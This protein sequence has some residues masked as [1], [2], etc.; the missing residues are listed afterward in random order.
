MEIFIIHNLK[1]GNRNEKK[2][3]RLIVYAI[4]AQ[5][6]FGTFQHF[7]V[8]IGKSQSQY[9]YRVGQQCKSLKFWISL[10]VTGM[11]KSHQSNDLLMYLAHNNL[12]ALLVTHKI[13]LARDTIHPGKKLLKQNLHDF[14][15]QWGSQEWEKSRP[16]C[17]L[18]RY[19]ITLFWA[20]FWHPGEA[21]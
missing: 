7:L 10:W 16:A 11:T 2:V 20:L 5:R 21:P 9:C 19:C 14:R 1:V 13:A 4:S 17:P 8:T 6:F 18:C 12:L 3:I 15:F